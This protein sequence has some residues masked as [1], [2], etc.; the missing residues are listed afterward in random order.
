MF[1]ALIGYL[2][3]RCIKGE[4]LTLLEKDQNWFKSYILEIPAFIPSRNLAKSGIVLKY[5]A[6]IMTMIFLLSVSYIVYL[7]INEQFCV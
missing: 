5:I 1:N 6:L 7:Q 3:K 2:I 4:Y